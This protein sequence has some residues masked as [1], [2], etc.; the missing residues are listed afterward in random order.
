M[1]VIRSLAGMFEVML[2]VHIIFLSN[3]KKWRLAT[4]LPAVARRHLIIGVC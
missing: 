3:E 4:Y 2:V 1:H